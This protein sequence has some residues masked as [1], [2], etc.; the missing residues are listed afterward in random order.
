MFFAFCQQA[1]FNGWQQ[2]I[3]NPTRTM[4]ET[5]RETEGMLQALLRKAGA[6]SITNSGD[7]RLILAKQTLT[8]CTNYLKSSER[9]LKPKSCVTEWCDRKVSLQ[10]FFS[11]AATSS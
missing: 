6:I 2:R 7:I 4:C 1:A 3:P 11:L 9:S 8:I 10:P 5:H